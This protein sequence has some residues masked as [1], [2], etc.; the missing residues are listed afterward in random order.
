MTGDAVLKEF[1][2]RLAKTLSEHEACGRF[3]GEEFIV[4]LPVMGTHAETRALTIIGQVT[5][6]RIQTSSR[7][8]QITCSG[9]IAYR[10]SW[11]TWETLL[12]RSDAAL[13]EA[14]SAGR[15][16]LMVGTSTAARPIDASS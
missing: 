14:K 12:E 9:G 11:D 15:N 7:P 6:S 10:E 8:L 3:G 2:A 13:Y 4:C 5:G 16:R 1:A